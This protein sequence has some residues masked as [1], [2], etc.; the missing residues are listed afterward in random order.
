MGLISRDIQ[1]ID[2]L[3]RSIHIWNQ[4]ITNNK[5]QIIMIKLERK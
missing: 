2:T 5:M 3:K 1:I 4:G